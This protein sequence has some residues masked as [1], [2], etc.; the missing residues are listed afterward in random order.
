VNSE[1]ELWL[2]CASTLVLA[3]QVETPHLVA[4]TSGQSI[5]G[6][7]QVYTAVALILTDCF[8]VVGFGGQR[9]EPQMF[10]VT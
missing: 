1:E 3:K 7:Q 5:Y 10:Q 8:D 6:C 2:E 4:V 9:P